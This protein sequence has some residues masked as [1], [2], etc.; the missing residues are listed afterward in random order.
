MMSKEQYIDLISGIIS[1]NPYTNRFKYSW[2]CS[3]VLYVSSKPTGWDTILNQSI[4]I[5]IKKRPFWERLSSWLKL[6]FIY[7]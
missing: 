4:D 7:S 1:K 2:I 6:K 5:K 3:V